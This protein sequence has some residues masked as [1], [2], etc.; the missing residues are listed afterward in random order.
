M[1]EEEKNGIAAEYEPL[2]GPPA[3]GVHERPGS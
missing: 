3:P 2:D 1:N